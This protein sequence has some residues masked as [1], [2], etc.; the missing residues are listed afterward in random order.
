M[1]TMPPPVTAG[2]EHIQRHAGHV[3]A[4][5]R[6][7]WFRQR[8]V[9]LW[10]TG[11]SGAGKSTLAFDLE[12]ALWRQGHAAFVLDG[13]NVRHGLNRNLGFS[14]ADR[15]ENIRRV[16][17]VAALMNDAGLLVISAFISPSQCDREMARE[18]IGEDRFL[19]VHVCTPMAVCEE[20]DPKALYQK[21][22]RGEIPE[23]TG[24][25]AP[26]DE[27]LHPAARIDTAALSP[28]QACGQL[29][30]L[31]EPYLAGP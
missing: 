20:R 25:S 16:A 17:E 8:P 27:P 7:S 10:L 23:F 21:A 18:I 1:T 11:L 22:R 4:M 29:Q 31:L 28:E 19:E 5:Q 9:T 13:D 30:R 26:Y 2:S 14:P 12:A 3:G 15:T 6:A 24:V